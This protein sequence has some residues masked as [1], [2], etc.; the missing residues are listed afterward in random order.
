MV[1]DR[2]REGGDPG[3]QERGRDGVTSGSFEPFTVEREAERAACGRGEAADY[4][5]IGVLGKLSSAIREGGTGEMLFSQEGVRR[6][7]AAR[8]D[9]GAAI[10]KGTD[11]IVTR[12]DKGIAYVK[13]LI[14]A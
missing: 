12:Y 2:A 13:R 9:D 6:S 4:D 7:A 10:E 14:G 11:V 5:M 3:A 1:L 8:T